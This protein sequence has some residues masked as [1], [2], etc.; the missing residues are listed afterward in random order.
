MIRFGNLDKVIWIIRTQ[1]RR[2]LVQGVQSKD[3]KLFEISKLTDRS[4]RKHR[5]VGVGVKERTLFEESSRREP[6]AT[7]PP[8]VRFAWGHLTQSRAYTGHGAYTA[9]SQEAAKE[10]A[11]EAEEWILAS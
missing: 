10:E 4:T 8:C 5:H 7:V 2:P 11:W 9:Y 1:I 6:M 3:L